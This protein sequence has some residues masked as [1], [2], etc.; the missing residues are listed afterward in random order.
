MGS[1]T[2]RPSES[3]DAVNPSNSNMIPKAIPENGDIVREVVKGSEEVNN[4]MVPDNDEL[5]YSRFN[6]T[7]EARPS[8]GD[9]DLDLGNSDR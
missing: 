5:P 6:V 3:F 7:V 2:P 4:D 9:E 1:P 8:V